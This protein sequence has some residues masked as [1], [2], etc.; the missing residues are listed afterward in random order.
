[1]IKFEQVSKIF[2][3]PNRKVNALEEV[4]LSVGK[5]EIFGVIGFSGAGKSTLL[6]LV[7]LLERPSEGRIVVNDQDITQIRP[8]ELRNLRRRIGMVFQTFNLFNSRT[9]YGNLAYPL[10]LAKLP[11]AQIDVRVK[12]LLQFVGLEDKADS[13]PEQL[14]G[15]QKQRVGIARALANSPDILI[16]DEATSALDPETT[17]DILRLLKK[18]NEDYQITILLITHEMNV[19][20]S[21]CDRVAVMENGRVIEQ[22]SV[23]DVF[24]NPQTKTTKNFIRSVLNDQL[25]PKL[26]DK[27]R[28][29]H[30]GR[31]YRL[32]FRDGATSEP[33][34]SR[35][36]RKYNLDYNIVYGSI[37]ELQGALFGSLIVELI[38]AED[39]VN[40]VVEELRTTVEVREVVDHES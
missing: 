9:V 15:G 19:I 30:V 2:S 4:S 14:S 16:C 29:H 5:G 18:V 40:K 21:I 13:Y 25:S 27:I 26:L 38:G 1:M 34:L 35:A 17:E 12:E 23:F 24:A 20:R 6:R 8:K 37:N 3:L 22:G 32:V 36:T 31:L 39:E 7:N 33:V 28:E 11:K 10:K